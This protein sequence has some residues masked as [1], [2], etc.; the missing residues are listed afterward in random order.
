M[1]QDRPTRASLIHIAAYLAVVAFCAVV[2]LWLAP[3][4]L[5]FVWVAAGWGSAS[6][7]TP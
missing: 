7:L 4:R 2:N 5:W 3:G 6:R 1:L